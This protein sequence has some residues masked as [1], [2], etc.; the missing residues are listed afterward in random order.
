MCDTEQKSL[1]IR[2]NFAIS[3]KFSCFTYLEHYMNHKIEVLSESLRTRILKHNHLNGVVKL[4]IGLLFFVFISNMCVAGDEQY[5]N[6]QAMYRQD[7]E[8]CLNSDARQSKEICIHEASAVR[9]ATLAG[10]LSNKNANQ[11]QHNKELRCEVH[12]GTDR[13]SC[14]KRMRGEGTQSGSVQE[15]GALSELTETVQPKLQK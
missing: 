14:L 1:P 6:I 7:R 15:G 3:H 4:N 11:F 5:S 2:L 9:K 12:S 10:K 8:T 13:E